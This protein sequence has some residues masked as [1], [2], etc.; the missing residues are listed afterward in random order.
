MRAT[1]RREIE[2]AGYSRKSIFRES[3]SSDA[4]TVYLRKLPCGQGDKRERSPGTEMGTA[5]TVF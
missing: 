2:L 1:E 4:L 5:A 3:S